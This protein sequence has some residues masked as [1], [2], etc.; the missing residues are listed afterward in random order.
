M[1][2][3]TFFPKAN[4]QF[5]I[6]SN[7]DELPSRQ[8]VPPKLYNENGVVML[9]PKDT[10]AGGSWIGLA[11]TNR[12]ACLLNGGFKPY[13]PASTYRLSRG[14]V[15]KKVLQA[16]NLSVFLDTC[17]LQGIAPFT[18][19]LVDWNKILQ[20]LELVWDG[21]QKHVR[22]VPLKPTI[23]SSATLYTDEMK[24][25]RQRWF[26]IFNKKL[27]TSA[28]AIMAFHKTAGNTSK[29]HS[30]LLKRK[31]IETTSITQITYLQTDLKMHY[32]DLLTDIHHVV[33]FKISG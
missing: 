15:V 7:R 13:K 14:L 28:E 24:T 25:D 6:T 5:I 4:G 31:H 30:V 22:Q 1:C 3:V 2:T 8:T 33:P 10:V 12:L 21:S 32:T 23:W 16:S 19:I 26:Q 29:T 20:V 27:D 11:S 9:Y 18:L 17:N